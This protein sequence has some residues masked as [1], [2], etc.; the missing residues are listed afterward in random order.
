LEGKV[1]V[2]DSASVNETQLSPSAPP[3]VPSYLRLAVKPAPIVPPTSVAETAI[4][5]QS[6]TKKFVLVGVTV[7]AFTLD[8]V[9]S[10]TVLVLV[11]I[12]VTVPFGCSL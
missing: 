11:A 3:V 4:P 10:S 8:A 7:K 6:P 12:E 2:K 1:I 5:M 9:P